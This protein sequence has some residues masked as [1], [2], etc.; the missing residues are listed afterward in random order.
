MFTLRRIEKWSF[1]MCICLS[2]QKITN[3]QSRYT[4]KKITPVC[5]GKTF[6]HHL[7]VSAYQYR[8]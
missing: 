3:L 6:A 2:G 5:K 7:L 4:C 8:S 1:C